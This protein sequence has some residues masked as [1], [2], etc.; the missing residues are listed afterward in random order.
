MLEKNQEEGQSLV[1]EDITPMHPE[2]MGRNFSLGEGFR[3]RPGQFGTRG[4]ADHIAKGTLAFRVLRGQT[5]L[6]IGH[7]RQILQKHRHTSSV[8]KHYD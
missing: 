3:G 2:R 6:I 5:S 4:D 8:M 1:Q 7:S